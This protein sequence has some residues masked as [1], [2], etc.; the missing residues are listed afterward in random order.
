M[1]E[2]GPFVLLCFVLFYLLFYGAGDWTYG[3]LCARTSILPLSCLPSPFLF[4]LRRSSCS[5]GL[6]WTL[7]MAKRTLELCIFLP[8]LP[9]RQDHRAGSPPCKCG[10]SAL[11]ESP[12]LNLFQEPCS[13]QTNKCEASKWNQVKPQRQPKWAVL[14]CRI[15]TSDDLCHVGGSGGYRIS[16]VW[17]W[18]VA[19]GWE[20]LTEESDSVWPKPCN[21]VCPTTCLP[22][23][24]I[25][26]GITWDSCFP[27]QSQSKWRERDI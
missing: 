26:T 21:R 2:G 3:L 24:E 17:S 7:C 15:I 16:L 5:P 9:G 23:W 6:L 25:K 4:V 12:E 8:S 13:A 14:P 20:P 22:L 11:G 10:I 1:E 18:G 19:P 27:L